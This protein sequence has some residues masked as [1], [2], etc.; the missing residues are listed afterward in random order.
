MV[1]NLLGNCRLRQKKARQ[2]A[3][4]LLLMNQLERDVRRIEQPAFGEKTT[5]GPVGLDISDLP[6]DSICTDENFEPWLV[7]FKGL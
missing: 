3:G 2:K 1:I 7:L 6:L 5:P 4:K